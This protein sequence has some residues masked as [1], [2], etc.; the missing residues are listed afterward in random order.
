[1][2][3]SLKPEDA[4]AELIERVAALAHER[5]PAHQAGS[6]AAFIGTYFA[7]VSPDDVLGPD[8]LDLYGAAVAHWNL[9]EGRLP[10]TARVRVYTPQFERHG[11]QSTHT[12][13]ETV[14]D[15]M[16]FLVD[17]VRME[18]SRHGLGIHLVIHPV[19]AVRRD[20][21]GRLRGVGDGADGND[22]SFIHVEIDRQRDPEVLDGLEA[23]LRRVLGDI[24]AAVEDWPDMRS[25]VGEVVASL[26][27]DPPPVDA[28][29][30]AEDMAFLTWLAEDHFTFL[31]FREY[32]LTVVDG[33]DALQSVPGSGLGILRD[34]GRSRV[35][36]SFAKAPAEVRRLARVPTV[37]TLTKANSRATVHRP[38]YLDYVGVKRFDGDGEPVGE[39]RFLGV[40]ASAVYNGLLA[41]IPRLR[42]QTD[43][44]LDRAGFRRSSHSG[45][46]LLAVLEGY[47]RDELLQMD[48]DELFR[49]AMG[50]L[51][52]QE[53]Q[54]VRLFVRRERFGRFF[55]CLVFLPRERY[56]TDTRVGI[57]KIL[58]RALQGETIEYEAHVSESVLARL[59]FVIH[60]EPGATVDY[61]VRDIERQLAGAVRAWSDDLRDALIDAHGEDVGL[62]LFR[63]YR[64]A[65]S[66]GYRADFLARAGVADIAHIEGLDPAGDLRT[67]LHRPLEAPRGFMRFKLFRSGDPLLLSDVLPVLE[68]LG[69]RVVDERPYE[70]DPTGS[71]P[72][73]IY[74]FGLQCDE[75]SAIA[76]ERL[77]QIFQ[78]AFAAV[79]RGASE[80]DG[81]NRLVL[82]ARL[83][84]R[85][86]VVLRAYARYLRQI[87]S[88]FSQT[89]MHDT[90]AAHPDIARQLVEL[91][92]NRFD[93]TITDGQR[94]AAGELAARVEAAI[95][96]VASLDED[97]ILRGFLHLILA[98]LRTSFFRVGPGGGLPDQLSFKF[99]PTKVA[100]LPLP[101]PQF[102]IWVYSPRTEGVHLRGGRVARGGIRWSDRRED[103][104]TEIL[105]LVKAQMVKNAVIVPVGAK[106]GFVVKRPPGEDRDALEREVEA[107][108]R[109]FISGL[110][111]LT[112]NL[113]AGG[114]RP[115]DRVVRYDGDDPYLVVAADKGTAGFS[116]IA[117]RI[118]AEYGFWL[119]DA[120][121]SGGSAGYDHKAMAI[122]ARGA[123][124][125][126][127][128]HFRHL[129][130]DI[131]TSDFTV[132]GIGDMSGDVFG[133]GMLLSRHTRLVGAF[134]H[135]H[136]FIDPNPDP[137]QSYRER[138]RLFRLPGSTWA[139]YDPA[140]LSSGGGVFA[141]AAKSIRLSPEARHVL[142]IEA[143]ALT[144]NEV[145]R[146]VLEAPVD[147]LWNG[148]VGTYVKAAAE[149]HAE[150]G[151]KA[152]DAVRVNANELRCRVVGEGGNLGFTQ[153]ARIDF[154]RAGGRV[155][156]DAIDNSG[157]VNCS[158]HEVNIKILL[159]AVVA[160][161]DLTNKQRDALL[162][163]VKDE[164][165]E[166]VLRDSYR[167][168][169]AL[170]NGCA[171]SSSLVDVHARCVR[172]LGQLGKLNRD[173][174][175]LPTE[176]A[177]AERKAA[178]EG[179]STPEFAVLLAYTKI[180][181][182]DDLLASD[183]PEDPYLSRELQRYFPT[184]FCERFRD[185][186]PEHRL[187]REI[188]ANAVSNDLVDRQGTTFAYRL[189]DETGASMPTIARARTVARDVFH[190]PAL[191]AAVEDLDNRVPS[192][193]Q[194]EM[195]LE[196]RKLVE[197]ATRWV[198]R[199]RRPPL[200]IAGEVERFTAG[201]ES[202]AAGLPALLSPMERDAHQRVADRLR[203]AGVPFELAN[204]VAGFEA[205]AAGLD[206]VEVAQDAGEPV[207]AVAAVYF[208]L[209]GHLQLHWLRDQIVAL[210]RDTRW[211]TLARAVLRDDLYGQ[212]RALTA[213]VLR[214]SPPGDAADARIE[215]WLAD[216]EEAALRSAQV[217]A[218]VKAGG[219]ADL[220]ILSV[221]LR[222]NLNL[223]QAAPAPPPG[224]QDG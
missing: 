36:E 137:E 88:T 42:R 160:D 69:A 60:I 189:A 62:D 110:L 130:I 85:D 8:V 177:F 157:G 170:T 112:D 82:L 113:V 126:V 184:T 122:T 164:V 154:S 224:S 194:T 129:G 175:C 180:A 141:R 127:K 43:L 97:R 109:S 57:Q 105:G 40:Y 205:L 174:E 65:F 10:G 147:L 179:L 149:S 136:V 83:P 200:D 198:L 190:L 3:M 66:A 107:C 171:Q 47:P 158:D 12:V 22:E 64:D 2:P 106:G 17:S 151:D 222:E 96:E 7:E 87:G 188:I 123:W 37:L 45:K 213:A 121:A 204:G 202:V 214:V 181:I 104:R 44:V 24:R 145:I 27:A 159:D 176:E 167:Q 73:W 139:D 98:T 102:E 216:H 108:Y 103:F 163:D 187:R 196:G 199:H 114:V 119:G 61:D 128:H 124:E 191:W 25:M 51:A 132:V 14:T 20:E 54:R 221:A 16:P 32:E 134:N 100:D 203:G 9:A 48:D 156:T 53:R 49:T 116:D 56:N 143:E 38:T 220:A 135:T 217:I 150:V 195:V 115:P 90:L 6:V 211:Q 41:D 218:D 92:H 18:L 33:E 138:E 94:A 120:F 46:D 153:R 183:L 169:Q 152:N 161:G 67:H 209:G 4:K 79:W 23:D 86:V 99:D 182:Y 172:L 35:S 165:A 95:G 192:D 118:S 155:N 11:W 84:Y 77:E 30:L 206:I 13:V 210:P 111:D 34:H 15:D 19:V 63:R 148:G 186:L 223:I 125:S 201:V 28:A 70:V 71:A 59:H 31:G 144:P 39:W 162:A 168:S 91:F 133:N 142:D 215:T 72:V 5:L 101:R 193:V 166:L 52:L 212:E 131:Q 173:L 140:L 81:F 117:N 1:M 21:H 178:G 185:R 58:L 78:E 146:A 68:N 89:Y 197:R 80:D 208:A 207:E 50:V 219:T 74:N 75:V 76:T 93:P 55:S 29:G 26:A